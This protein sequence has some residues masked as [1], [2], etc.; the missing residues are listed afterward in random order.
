MPGIAPEKDLDSLLEYPLSFLTNRRLVPHLQSLIESIPNAWKILCVYHYKINVLP[1]QDPHL[2]FLGESYFRKSLRM[3][4]ANQQEIAKYY[5]LMAK[6]ADNYNAFEFSVNVALDRRDYECALT[7]AR[8]T[9]NVYL[10][11]GYLLI[12]RCHNLRAKYN[13]NTEFGKKQD[14]KEV[15]INLNLAVK[16]MPYSEITLCNAGWQLSAESVAVLALDYEK[17]TRFLRSDIQYITEETDRRFA[18][19][20]IPEPLDRTVL[21]FNFN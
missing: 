18:L 9:T 20:D 6:R 14:I 2:T 5:L 13:L 21:Y 10:S 19:I 17:S 15:L 16:L 11:A 8:R 3:F 7:N 1:H 12:A 4:E